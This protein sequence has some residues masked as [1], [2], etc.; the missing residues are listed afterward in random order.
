MKNRFI[1]SMIVLI[2]A[3]ATVFAA[4]LRAQTTEEGPG[5]SEQPNAPMETGQAYPEDQDQADSAP[6]ANE[7]AV[8]GDQ[9]VARISMLHGDVSTQRGDSGD[10]SAA[11]LNA[12]VVSGD[13][14]STGNDA[15]AEV[16]LDYANLLRLGPNAQANIANLT[17]RNI[18]IQLG[19]GIANYTV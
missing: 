3:L 16:Q 11:T 9:G 18:Q 19:Q 2:L 14:V 5:P 12:P 6:P 4:G 1:A 10:W 17:K 8:A 15:R 13:K 7:S